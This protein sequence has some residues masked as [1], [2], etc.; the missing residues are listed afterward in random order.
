MAGDRR[1]YQI[2]GVLGQGGFGRVYRARLQGPQGFVKD[3]AIKLLND[4]D[5]PE[6]VLRRFRD[7]SRILGLIRDRA[8]INVDPPTR[9]EGR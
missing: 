6:S 2:L 7:E 5:A 4:P 9:L 1:R 3:V 8:V